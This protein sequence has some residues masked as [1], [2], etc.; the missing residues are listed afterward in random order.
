MQGNVSDLEFLTDNGVTSPTEIDS[1]FVM[2]GKWPHQMQ[3]SYHKKKITF[4]V[5]SPWDP[6]IN[7][8]KYVKQIQ[9]AYNKYSEYYL[10]NEGLS[11]PSNYEDYFQY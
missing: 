5:G 4:T 7:D 3:N 1:A 11:L 9:Q 2:S 10:S 6:N 8:Q